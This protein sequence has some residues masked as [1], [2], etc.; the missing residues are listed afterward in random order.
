M[1][2]RAEVPAH[3]ILAKT[4]LVQVKTYMQGMGGSYQVRLLVRLARR[5]QY[6]VPEYLV[7][8]PLS[9]CDS[10]DR[11]ISQARKPFEWRS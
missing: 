9:S 1:E 10:N 5:Q 7:F 4:L 3:V 8:L 2:K 11:T 6:I